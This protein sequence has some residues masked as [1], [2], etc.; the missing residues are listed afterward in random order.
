MSSDEEYLDLDDL[1]KSVM[2]NNEEAEESG[3]AVAS[4][5]DE[6]T[7]I[8][9]EELDEADLIDIMNAVNMDLDDADTEQNSAEGV[10]TA[11]GESTESVKDNDEDT[12]NEF[13]LTDEMTEMDESIPQEDAS[14]LDGFAIEDFEVLEPEAGELSDEEESD[15][16]SDSAVSEADLDFAISDIGAEDAEPAEASQD[17]F[18]IEDFAIEDFGEADNTNIAEDIQISA[19]EVEAMFAQSDTADKQAASAGSIEDDMLA[20]LESMSADTGDNEAMQQDDLSAD[21]NDESADEG[22][23]K[24]K[25]GLH[26][27]KR[28]KRKK[29]KKAD[30]A[31]ALTADMQEEGEKVPSTQGLFSKLMAF[32]TETDEDEK[33]GNEESGLNPSDENKNILNELEEEDKKKKKKKVKGKKIKEEEAGDEDSEDGEEAEGKKE[34][35]RR[36]KKERETAIEQIG[37]EDEPKPGKKISKKNI[38]VITSLC[39]TLTAVIVV[40]CNIVPGFFDK[41]AAREA[42]Y[43]SDYEKSY[44]L[45]YGKKLDSSD[46]IIYNKSRIVLEMNRKLDAYHNYIGIGKGVQALDALMA[47]VQKYPDILLEAEEYHVTQ[48]VDAVYETI[49]NI[50]NDKYSISEDMAKAII[51]YDDLTYTK[52]LDS[53][54]NGTVFVNPDAELRLPADDLLPEEQDMME[55]TQ[56]EILT[57]AV[58]EELPVGGSAEGTSEV[59]AEG[60]TGMVNSEAEAQTQGQNEAPDTL[61]DSVN[62]DAPT[63]NDDAEQTGVSADDGTYAPTGNQG[64]LIQGIR[65]PIS[66]EVHG[67]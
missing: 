31:S 24:K 16:L 64:E 60:T 62:N 40:L 11:A 34:K 37:V 57:D 4:D 21:G 10:E 48:E 22:T 67:R 8:T 39:L 52:K 25:K 5:L 56:E 54:V 6:A 53:I 1:L 41:R 36:K 35:K 51:A 46:T 23:D 26:S 17:E 7:D 63:V 50:L 61:P 29:N 33:N 38:A 45:L 18:A 3:K 28:N 32:L 59:A 58:Q 2:E 19:D 66:V 49:L 47:G 30:S 65:Q 13:A 9:Q 55:E 15:S 14:S 20:M 43:K 42:Y 44:D 27:G 12:L